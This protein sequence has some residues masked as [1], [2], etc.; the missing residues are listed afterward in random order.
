MSASIFITFGEPQHGW[1][2]VCFRYH[3]FQLDFDA[4]DVLFDP[5]E[6][7]CNAIA[8]LQE[9]Y[10]RR[11]EWWLEPAAYIFEFEKKGS[12][13][14]LTISVTDDLNNSNAPEK[15]LQTI[16]LGRKQMF[17]PFITALRHFDT[18]TYEYIHWPYR[19]DAAKL[20]TLRAD[21]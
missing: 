12:N 16:E 4:S 1:L 11:V 9:G 8:H 10:P 18:Y 17:K 19:L 7:L 2:P 13:V 21:G 5:L 6:M 14:C 15:V 3:D 20:K